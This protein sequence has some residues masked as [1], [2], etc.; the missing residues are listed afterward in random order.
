MVLPVGYNYFS[1]SRDPRFGLR[2]TQAT[3]RFIG[4]RWWMTYTK[5][6]RRRRFR[7]GRR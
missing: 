5:G 2:V 1:R 3:L 4:I 6:R 7:E